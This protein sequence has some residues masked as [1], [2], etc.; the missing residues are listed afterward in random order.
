[1]PGPQR[2]LVTSVGLIV[3][4]AN[5]LQRRI[6]E[7]VEQATGLP[8]TWFETLVRL[9]RS[10]DRPV[11]MNEIAAQVSF[12]PSSFTRLIDA[13]EGAG[14]VDRAPDPTNRRATIICI[15]ATGQRRLAKALAVHARSAQSHLVDALSSKDLDAL[16]FVARKLRDANTLSR[17][18]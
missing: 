18:D 1:M 15:T 8:G 13:M 6:A 10:Q 4:A 9:S 16:E 11:R 17:T 12:P 2:D 5:Y 7:D 3:E 14:L